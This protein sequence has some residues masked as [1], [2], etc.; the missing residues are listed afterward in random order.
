[1]KPPKLHKKSSDA[2]SDIQTRIDTYHITLGTKKDGT[3]HMQRKCQHRKRTSRKLYGKR[4]RMMKNFI[5]SRSRRIVDHYDV[6][7]V[8]NLRVKEMK[9]QSKQKGSP[10]ARSVN[11]VLSQNAICR[12]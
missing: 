2:I 5:P 4:N 3:Y 12:L 1:M 6:V 11:R 8:E 7:V 10:S 9:E